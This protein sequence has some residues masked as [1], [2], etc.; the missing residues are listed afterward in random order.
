LGHGKGN[1]LFAD[2]YQWEEFQKQ[3]KQ[4]N[5][6]PAQAKLP[7]K[8]PAQKKSL[9]YKEK[10]ELL[11]IDEKILST[12]K[13][14]AHMHTLLEDPSLAE[15]NDKLLALCLKLKQAQEAL[16]SLYARWQEL[17]DKKQ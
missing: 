4:E 2:Y 3:Q 12:E 15:N 5:A 1:Y 8:Q 13:A 16:E 14:I 9:S 17:E 7:E 6:A 10:Q 11:T